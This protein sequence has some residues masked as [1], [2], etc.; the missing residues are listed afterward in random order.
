MKITDVTVTLFAWDNIPSTNY[1]PMSGRLG[2]TVQMG[3]VT[4]STDEGVQGHAFLGHSGQGADF[5]GPSLINQLKPRLMGKDPLQREALWQ[6]CML[7]VRRTTIRAVGAADIALWDLAGKVAGLPIYKMLGGYRTSVH[8]YV[9]S[10]VHPAI[11]GYVEEAVR[12]KSEGWDAYKIHPP[13]DPDTDIRVCE[14][15]R[16]AVGDEHV[17]MLDS[18]WSYQYPAAVK[19]GRAIEEMGYHWYEDPL[20]DDDIYGYVKL[21]QKLDIPILATEA[22]PGGLTA[23]APWIT[24]G[25]TDY[26]RGDVQIKGGITAVIKTS[27]LAEAFHMNYELHH[28]GNSLNNIANLH[29]IM[30]I[31][32]CEYFEVILPDSTQKYGLIEDIKVEKGGIIHIAP[33]DRPGLGAQIDFDLIERKKTGVLA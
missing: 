3:L 4:I 29:A 21:R 24:A 9:S 26:L 20:P 8:A 13:T 25:A 12:Y 27:H 18:T 17:M 32:N 7:G 15:V 30:A 5:D 14:A 19:V 31:K 16:K 28:G 33:F 2:G 22:T 6:A 1:S 10:P 23:Y 11:E